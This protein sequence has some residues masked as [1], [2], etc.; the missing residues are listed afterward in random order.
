[1]VTIECT[2]NQKLNNTVC[3]S[4]DIRI[5]KKKKSEN[6]AYIKT[7]KD[8]DSRLM[9]TYFIFFFIVTYKKKILL[10]Q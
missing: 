6:H 2:V 3:S 9:I 1:M 7:F 4:T 8:V 10:L 5:Q